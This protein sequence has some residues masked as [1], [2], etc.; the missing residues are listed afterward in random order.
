M[1]KSDPLESNEERPV[2][3]RATYV[4]V[5]KL[6]YG[7]Y[8]IDLDKLNVELS[9]LRKL[10]PNTGKDGGESR[11]ALSPPP[12]GDDARDSS[13][14][15]DSNGYDVKVDSKGPTP[16]KGTGSGGSGG[17]GDKSGGK[18]WSATSPQVLPDKTS[19]PHQGKH[20]HYNR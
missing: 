17:I 13:S 19:T 7:Q 4:T 9:R 12:P 1:E 20:H 11:A 5:E 2:L 16:A 10:A 6:I 15:V 8:N 18:A 14:I 3:R